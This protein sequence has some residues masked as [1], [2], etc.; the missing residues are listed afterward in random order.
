MEEKYQEALT[1][2]NQCDY[3]GAYA[4]IIDN[5]LCSTEKGDFYAMSVEKKSCSNISI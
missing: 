5:G 3:E 1:L 2:Y 4:I